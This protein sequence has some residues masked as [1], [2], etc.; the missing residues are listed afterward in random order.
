VT[1]IA[2][3]MRDIADRL[4]VVLDKQEEESRVQY[5][6]ALDLIEQWWPRFDALTRTDTLPGDVDSVSVPFIVAKHINDLVVKHRKRRDGSPYERLFCLLTPKEFASRG[7]GLP[8]RVAKGFERTRDWFMAHAH[9]PRESTEEVDEKELRAQFGRFETILHSFVGRFFTSTKELDDVLNQ[10][11]TNEQV[12]AALPLLSFPQH[13]RYFFDRLENPNWVEPLRVRGLF[14][15]PPV[16]VDVGNGIVQFLQWPESRYL[17]RMARFVPGQVA[18]ILRA[19]RTDNPWV[20]HDLL[21][22]AAAMPVAE[23]ALLVPGICFAARSSALGPHFKEA[24]DLCARLANEDQAP[25][26]M[27]LAKALFAPKFTDVDRDPTDRRSYWC[28]E[29]LPKVIPALAPKKPR[30]FTNHLCRLLKAAMAADDRLKYEGDDDRFREWRPSIGEH[31]HNPDNDNAVAMAEFVREGFEHAIRHGQMTLEAARDI[32]GKYPWL[33]Y[34]RLEMHLIN[35]FAEQGP[36]LARRVMM[37][38]GMFDA[39]DYKH[40]YAM[41]MGRRFPLLTAEEQT[42]WLGWVDAGPDM[43]GFDESP[44]KGAGRDPTEDDRKNRVDYWKFEKLHWIREHLEE[45]RRSFYADMT[46]KH[47]EPELADLNV[48]IGGMA[49]WQCESPFSAEE[50]SRLAFAE[51][52]DKVTSWQ[53]VK[54]R[55][56]GPNRDGLNAEFG[57]YLATDR[58]AFSKEAQ[59]LI[60]RPAPFVR[61][62][63]HGMTEAARASAGIDIPAVLDLC[64][65]VLSR[66][67]G[68]CTISTPEQEPFQDKD[69]QWTRNAVSDF[70]KQVCAARGEKVPRYP[71]ALRE[72]LWALLEVLHRD[73][74]ESGLVHDPAKDDPRVRDYLDV[75]INSPRGK[76][77]EAVIDYGR[78]LIDHTK[79][80][81][82]KQTE[83]SGHFELAPEIKAVLE[84]HVAA[85]NRSREALAIVGAH[86]NVVYVLGKLWL[87]ENAAVIFNLEGIESEPARPEGWAAWNAYL[88]WTQPH[89]EF[90]RLFKRQFACAVEQAAK[91][92]LPKQ[93]AHAQPMEHLGRHLVAFYGRGQ[94]GL[95]DDGGLLRRFLS[96]AAPDIRR[97]AIEFVGPSLEGDQKIPKEAIERFMTLWDTYWADKGKADAAEKPDAHLFGAWFGCGK[98]PAEWALDRLEQ[99]MEVVELPEPDHSLMKQL[100]VLAPGNIER[101]TLIVDR[102]IRADKEGWHVYGW[103][104]SIRQILEGALKAGDSARETAGKMIDHLGRRG[105]LE[106]GDLL[107][108][109]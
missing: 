76:A 105:Y 29:G 68:E 52:V 30:P 63:I 104:E 83:T 38:R 53:P 6:N 82:A 50:L 25:A 60:G 12:D 36:E 33:I 26:A 79:Q 67:I 41:L 17:A 77:V 46:A 44:R 16:G 7:L 51:A 101:V 97:H 8:T 31:E 91:V 22:A 78:W 4:P 48:G 45:E 11:A 106:Y 74:G 100:A 80:A 54:S 27:K 28:K 108:R 72:R 37:D 107:G 43:S 87:G 24:A 21:E 70:I 1:F 5:D 75:A 98:F 39:H 109:S 65:W 95:D 81:G 19:I 23:A 3:A 96:E 92:Q 2:H 69:W 14:E 84:W 85:P 103:R 47:G 59:V 71:I 10:A 49:R 58:A 18:R 86:I 62:F 34:K 9:F 56:E 32:L 40:E 93:R 102:M 64:R 89:I 42:A 55:F 15:E 35:E 20:L 66:P 90:Y 88:C 73:R 57:R 99:F 94:L 13:V 61:T